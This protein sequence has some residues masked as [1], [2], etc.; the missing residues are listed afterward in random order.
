MAAL[1]GSRMRFLRSPAAEA[2]SVVFDIRAGGADGFAASPDGPGR[3]VYDMFGGQ[4]IYF[5][6]PDQL[7]IDYPGYFRMLCSPAAG[8]VQSAVLSDG[9][10]NVL[11]AYPFFTIPL[12]GGDEA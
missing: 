3:P 9:P 5:E 8:L 6:E 2:A 7:F 10:G 1:I 11:A 4:L 12:D